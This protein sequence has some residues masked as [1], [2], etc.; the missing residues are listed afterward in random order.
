MNQVEPSAFVFMRVGNHAGET[1]EQILERKMQEFRRTGRIFWGYGGATCHPLTR[2]QPFARFHVKNNVQVYLVMEL[3]DS[4]ANPEILPARQYSEDGVTWLPIPEGIRVTGSRYA[5]VLD[6]IAPGDL[7]LD[8]A[9]YAVDIGPSRGKLAST[10]L[11]GRVDK[12][13]LVR[14]PAPSKQPTGEVKKRISYL[15]RLQEPFAVML[16]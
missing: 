1:F 11:H 7:E 10:Y 12:G 2:V 9:Q 3:I 4:R 13:C 6:E 15:A 8:L 5:L 16:R 14:C